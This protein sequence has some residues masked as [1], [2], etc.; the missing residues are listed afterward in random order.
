MR[1]VLFVLA[2]LCLTLPAR[3][4]DKPA[5]DLVPKL[6]LGGPR[7]SVNAPSCGDFELSPDLSGCVACSMSLYLPG[8]GQVW[9]GE[10]LKGLAFL[11]GFVAPVILMAEIDQSLG[12]A[13][14]A[15]RI[16]P[17]AFLSLSVWGWGIADA[18]VVGRRNAENR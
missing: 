12:S 5:I 6:Q 14:G 9:N 17:L 3:A 16:M 8:L 4:D 7:P 10:P 11:L 13:N 18:F 2:T 15:V 1:A